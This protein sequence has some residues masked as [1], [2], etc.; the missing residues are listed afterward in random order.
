MKRSALGRACALVG[1]QRQGCA[2]AGRR[3]GSPGLGRRQVAAAMKNSVPEVNPALL[4]RC[5]HLGRLACR[6]GPPASIIRVRIADVMVPYSD[7]PRCRCPPWGSASV[8][9][10]RNRLL[11]PRRKPHRLSAGTI[12]ITIQ[13]VSGHGWQDRIGGALGGRGDVAHRSASRSARSARGRDELSA[14]LLVEF[15][16]ASGRAGIERERHRA[17]HHRADNCTRPCRPSWI[18]PRRPMG[19]APG[20]RSLAGEVALNPAPRSPPLC[21]WADCR[22]PRK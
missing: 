13:G 9:P 14:S 19:L 1:R 4:R 2:C 22:W 15:I 18:R 16:A 20:Q 5:F 17:R 6:Y 7:C 8:M 11:S 3:P 12:A 10:L 21:T